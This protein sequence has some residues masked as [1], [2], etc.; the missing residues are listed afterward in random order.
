MLRSREDGFTFLQALS[1]GAL[2][3]SAQWIISLLEITGSSPIIFF[4]FSD[5]DRRS[6]ILSRFSAEHSIHDKKDNCKRLTEVNAKNQQSADESSFSGVCNNDR[7]PNVPETK[8]RKA[9]S[10]NGRIF[11]CPSGGENL[12]LP[13]LVSGFFT[14]SDCRQLILFLQ[15]LQTKGALQRKRNQTIISM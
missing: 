15:A 10:Y 7:N 2:S 12:H 13:R 5:G 3:H 4:P 14:L 1:H 8:K 6:C 11:E 9:E